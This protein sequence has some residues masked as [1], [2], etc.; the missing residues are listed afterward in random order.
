MVNVAYF[1]EANPNYTR[2]SIEEPNKESL[3][4]PS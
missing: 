2:V 3:L 1:Q 4:P